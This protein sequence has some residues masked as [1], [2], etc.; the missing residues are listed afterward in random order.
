MVRSRDTSQLSRTDPRR[1][2]GL[3]VLSLISK[4]R[5]LLSDYGLFRVHPLQLPPAQT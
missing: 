2:K 5:M 3:F 1:H 4:A